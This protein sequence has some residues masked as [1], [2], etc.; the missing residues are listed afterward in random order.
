MFNSHFAWH[1]SNQLLHC[2]QDSVDAVQLGHK[3]VDQVNGG[4]EEQVAQHADSLDANS[5]VIISHKANQ[6]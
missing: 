5:D 6:A 2:C 1:D 4:I 3:L